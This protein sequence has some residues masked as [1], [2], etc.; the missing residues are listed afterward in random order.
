MEPTEVNVEA[1]TD[2][3][4]LNDIQPPGSIQLSFENIDD[5]IINLKDIF[6]LLFQTFTKGMIIKFGN[7][8]GTVDLDKVNPDNINH[9][10]LFFNSIGFKINFTVEKQ[11]SCNEIESFTDAELT[12][13]D[14][15][16]DEN[17]VSKE[18]ETLSDYFVK[19][20]STNNQK[21]FISFS[22]FTDASKCSS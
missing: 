7:S 3:L 15:A 10:N 1:I 4:F 22:F 14:L 13:P 11:L 5:G 16:E 9:I 8:S 21:Y 12:L 2:R 20:T 17:I 19:L 6:E 18:P